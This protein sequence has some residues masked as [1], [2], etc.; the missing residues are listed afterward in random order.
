MGRREI[1]QQPSLLIKGKGT[2]NVGYRFSRRDTAV[3]PKLELP[4]PLKEGSLLPKRGM[5]LNQRL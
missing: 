1:I 5:L 3:T 2:L 4:P